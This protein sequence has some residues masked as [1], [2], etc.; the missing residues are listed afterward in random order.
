MIIIVK[1][2]LVFLSLLKILHDLKIGSK[3]EIWVV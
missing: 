3:D 2:F 1:H